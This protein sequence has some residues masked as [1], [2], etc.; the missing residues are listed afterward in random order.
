MPPGLIAQPP[1]LASQNPRDAN[2]AIPTPVTYASN[3]HSDDAV[4]TTFAP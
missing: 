1:M 4:F 3:N 2:E